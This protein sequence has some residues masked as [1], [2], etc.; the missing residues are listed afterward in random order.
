MQPLQPALGFGIGRL[1]DHHL[2]AQHTAERLATPGQLRLAGTPP[3]RCAFPD[4][5][6]PVMTTVSGYSRWAGRC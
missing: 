4:I 5:V 1:A 6:L 3:A 2:R